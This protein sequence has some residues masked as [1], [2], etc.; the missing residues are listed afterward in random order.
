MKNPILS[1]KK[2]FV[3]FSQPPHIKS[4][5]E[6]EEDFQ[7]CQ[8]GCLPKVDLISNGKQVLWAVKKV[9]QCH[10][11][12]LYNRMNALTDKRER[13]C[14]S[15]AE[16][17]LGGIVLFLLKK[18]SR[19][20]M[21]QSYRE[22]DFIRNYRKIFKL[23]CPSMSAVEDFYRLMSAEEFDGLKASL[24]ATLIEKRTLHSHRLFGKYF[25]IAVDATGVHSS[26]RHHWNECTHQ[27]SKNDVVT[28]MN[29]VLEAKLVCSNGLSLSLCSEWITNGEEYVK[30]DCEL[31]AFK[32]LAVRLKQYFPRLPVCLLFDG[33][34][35]NGPV[36]DICK[37]NG[38]QWIAVFKEGNLPS[39][40]E[41]LKMLPCGAF[42]TLERLM[43]HKRTQRKYCWC[44]DIDYEKRHVH[45]IRCLEEATGKEGA[46]E[47][48]HF[49]YLTSIPQ[50]DRTVEE[51]VEAGRDRW[52]IEDSF[53][54]QKNRGFEMQH[55]FS[56]SSFTAFC[57]WYQALQLAHIIYQFV[58]KTKE[59]GELLKQQGKTIQHL[60]ENFLTVI[61]SQNLKTFMDEFDAWIAKPRQ[62]RLC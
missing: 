35:C 40:H 55:L 21:D 42:R 30:Q 62:V 47:K 20:A 46:V 38:W 51:C 11:S 9:L 7:F 16:L 58:V 56:R 49:E 48:H 2:N 18:K 24:I 14:Y 27:T 25:T 52:H 33:L 36:M 15:A 34:Y 3:F 22:Q 39:V 53:N 44:N 17:V 43:P 59:I 54:E 32:R 23:R 8:Y 61:Y 13:K 41:E 50:N 4:V 12:D 60:W 29:H 19:H 6:S 31:K 37:E 26:R 5:D 57:N 28:W 10:F 45:W 1:D